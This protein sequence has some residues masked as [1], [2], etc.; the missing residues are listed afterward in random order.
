MTS[1]QDIAVYVFLLTGTILSARGGKLTVAGAIT[2]GFVGLLVFKGAGFT[3]LTIL[4]VF[5]LLGTVATGWQI[6]TKQKLGL[7]EKES[8]RRTTGQVIANGGVAAILGG[9]AWFFPA[10]K[11]VLTLMIAGSLASATADTLSSELGSLYGRRFYDIISLKRAIPGPDGV[12]SMEGTL[13]GTAGAALIAMVYCLSFGLSNSTWVI[14][15][16]GTIG[17]LADSLLGATLERRKLVGNDTVNF[18]NTCV[19]AGVCLLLH[20][21]VK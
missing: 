5:F 7:A 11:P 13:T 4:I 2:A 18:L 6:K 21:F 14:I 9:A 20:L 19:G 15:I 17:N 1:I 16:A 8:N 10:G 12:I 3:G